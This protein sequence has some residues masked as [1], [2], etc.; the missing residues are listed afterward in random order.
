[1]TV[2][3]AVAAGLLALACLATGGAKLAGTAGMRARAAHLRV[4][5]SGY[6][7]IGTLEALAAA[8]LVAGVWL[9]VLGA[10]AA[11]GLVA[12]MAGAVVM[13]ARS[14][15]PVA[16]TAPALVVGALAASA[17]VLAVLRF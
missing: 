15:E 9:P 6:V 16:A 8:G 14:G 13:H 5:W 2:A 4:P 10:A 3:Y 7:V 11:A 12:L 1:M 17:L